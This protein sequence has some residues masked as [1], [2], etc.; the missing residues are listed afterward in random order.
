MLG[1]DVEECEVQAPAVGGTIPEKFEAGFVHLRHLD[2]EPVLWI[3]CRKTHISGAVLAAKARALAETPDT[4]PA[5][6]TAQAQP[7][8]DEPERGEEDSDARRRREEAD[9]EALN[10]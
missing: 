3:A 4:A 5:P 10:A 2:D 7:V 6:E 9:L 1:C 8:D